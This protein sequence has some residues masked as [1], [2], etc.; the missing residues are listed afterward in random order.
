MPF[1]YYQRLNRRQQAIYRASDKVTEVRL[2][3]LDVA[4]KHAA[5]LEQALLAE[6]G[7]AEQRAAVTRAANRLACEIC[8]QLQIDP[9][10]V[11]VLARRPREAGSELHGLYT[12]EE[13]Q[14]AEIKLWMRTAQR[15]QVVA[16]KAFLRT[17]LHEVGHH[18][19]Y[20]LFRFADSYH[21]QGFFQRESS[22]A[23]QLLASPEPV[24]AQEPVG[25]L[26]RKKGAGRKTAAAVTQDSTGPKWSGPGQLR[27]P[28]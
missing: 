17:L 14:L 13:G 23:R 3:A 25:K 7:S 11:R 21:T 10:R 6:S 24:G 9:V 2:P 1:A 16:Y 19:D 8:A 5:Q 15:K 26:C 12:W 22:L 4:R 20:H 28:F 18:L 27:L